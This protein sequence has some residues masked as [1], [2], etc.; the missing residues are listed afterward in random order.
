MDELTLLRRLDA[1]TA[2][3]TRAALTDAFDALD[4]RMTAAEQRGEKHVAKRRRAVHV[5]RTLVMTL[6]AAAVVVGLVMTDTIGVAGLRPGASAEAAELLDNAAVDTIRTADPVVR[7]GQYLAITTDHV[8]LNSDISGDTQ[9]RWLDRGTDTTYIPYDRHDEWSLVRSPEEPVDYFSPAAKTRALLQYASTRALYDGKNELIRGRDGN[10]YG[11]PADEADFAALPR[12]ARV[13]LN[14]I[15]RT[16]LGQGQSPDGEALEWIA[17]QLRTGIVPAD[18]R[19]AM[20]RAAALIPGVTVTEKETVLDGRTGVAI[21]R[22][23]PATGARVE[24]VIEPQTG[25]MIGERRVATRTG[26]GIP[27]GKVT[28][29]SAVTVKV[30]GTAPTG[31]EHR[32]N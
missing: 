21:G 24:I 19:A 14:R 28:E 25:L 1:D 7:P 32:V 26:Y 10:F 4:D 29:S 30:V 31:P 15:Y 8:N 13:L 5:R 17:G 2:A 12:D 16:T 23:E 20:Y 11:T 22:V 27:A 18:L 3:P 9:L 6:A